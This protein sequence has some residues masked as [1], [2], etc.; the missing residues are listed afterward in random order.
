MYCGVKH[1]TRL[2]WVGVALGLVFFI[3]LMLV[4]PVGV[5]TQFVVADGIIANALVDGVIRYLAKS[6]RWRHNRRGAG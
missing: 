5:S 3:A 4:K 2:T 6:A 1:D